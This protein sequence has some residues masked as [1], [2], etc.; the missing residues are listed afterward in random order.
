MRDRRERHFERGI[1]TMTP[2]TG[3]IAALVVGA[4][5]LV[6]VAVWFAMPGSRSGETGWPPSERAA[7]MRSC[8]EQCRKS[9]GVTEDKYPLCDK[10]CTCSADEG[11]KIMT[12]AELGVVAQAISSGNA[13]EEQ[14]AKMD[15]LKA[16][17]MS[18]AMGAAPDKK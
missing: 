12:T 4:A 15:R 14:T 16:A 13:S 2:R 10:A 3:L 8:V 18:C 11:E 17:G 1:F 9:P 6:A 5:A 7:F